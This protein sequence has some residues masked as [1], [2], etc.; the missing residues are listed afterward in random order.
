ME[1]L[2]ARFIGG[3]VVVALGLLSLVTGLFSLLPP[4]DNIAV[5][6]LLMVL[7]AILMPFGYKLAKGAPRPGH[8]TAIET[9]RKS[10]L[11]TKKPKK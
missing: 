7:G 2:T 5:G 6:I 3:I 10:E 1:I 11:L 4:T 8:K 9:L